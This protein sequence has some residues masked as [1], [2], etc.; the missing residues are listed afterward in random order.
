[1]RPESAAFA[2]PHVPASA[3]A[4]QANVRFADM[5]WA[6]A[7]VVNLPSCRIRSA[8]AA[9]LVTG[10]LRLGVD[11]G[12]CNLLVTPGQEAEDVRHPVRLAPSGSELCALH[13]VLGHRDDL[14]ADED[15]E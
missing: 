14:L 9:G 6:P 2:C 1:M 7:R 13:H 8:V 4:M 12:L 10:V 11:P 5:E 15:A 3:T